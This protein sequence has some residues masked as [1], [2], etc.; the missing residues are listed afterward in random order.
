MQWRKILIRKVMSVAFTALPMNAHEIVQ[1]CAELPVQVRDASGKELFFIVSPQNFWAQSVK[2]K[3]VIEPATPSDAA[4]LLTQGPRVEFYGI[5]YSPS[6][7]VMAL[8]GK[9]T[10]INFTESELCRDYP[11]WNQAKSNSQPFKLLAAATDRHAI[12][13]INDTEE[14]VAEKVIQFLDNGYETAS[15][16]KPFIKNRLRRRITV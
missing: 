1:A 8:T 15:Q 4:E 5:V 11:N 6:Y 7:K 13:M 9:R 10:F 16:I 14:A 3:D 2:E 12:I